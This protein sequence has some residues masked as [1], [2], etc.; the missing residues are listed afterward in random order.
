MAPS[1]TF[2][3]SLKPHIHTRIFDISFPYP[4]ASFSGF[5]SWFSQVSSNKTLSSLW[6][7]A[8]ENPSLMCL[9]LI[10]LV[11]ICYCSLFWCYYVCPFV[12]LLLFCNSNLMLLQ[13]LILRRLI[14]RYFSSSLLFALLSEG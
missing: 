2:S 5:P 11:S 8:A 7:I 10:F 9:P 14:C 13:V 3:S 12:D 4:F 1:S 6:E